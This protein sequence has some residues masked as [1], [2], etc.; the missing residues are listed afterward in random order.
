MAKRY[1]GSQGGY[2]G[3]Q[4]RM[5]QEMQ[6]AGM[7]R[8]DMSAIANLPQEVMIKA[9][10]DPNDY[11]VYGLDDTMR[12]IDHQKME[13]SKRKKSGKYPEMY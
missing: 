12:S 4:A 6:D 2:A 5:T 3:Y 8:E 10:P 7:I 1:H 9:Y 11:A 13:D